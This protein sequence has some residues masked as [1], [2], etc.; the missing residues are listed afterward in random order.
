MQKPQNRDRQLLLIGF[1]DE[2]AS[3][4]RSVVLSKLRAVTVR[5]ALHHHRINTAPVQGFGAYL[6]VV[7]NNSKAKIKNRRVEVWLL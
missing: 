1:G 7:S 5:S 4:E 2:K 3:A 6:P